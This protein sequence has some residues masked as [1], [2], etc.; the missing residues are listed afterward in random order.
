M[1]RHSSDVR[2]PL[3]SLG[4]A[5]RSARWTGITSLNALPAGRRKTILLGHADRQ[6]TTAYALGNLLTRKRP[7]RF[8]GAP[9]IPLTRLG[10]TKVHNLSDVERRAALFL[11]FAPTVVDVREQPALIDFRGDISGDSSP[12]GTCPPPKGDQ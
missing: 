8:S 10:S 5:L 12:V 11:L 9:R 1:S 2:H 6:L 7:W 3:W 4:R